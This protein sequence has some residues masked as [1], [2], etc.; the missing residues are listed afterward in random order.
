MS[1]KYRRLLILFTAIFLPFWTLASPIWLT[2]NGISPCWP[3][4]WLL[5]FS[6]KN[7]IGRASFAGTSLGFLMDAWTI[8]DVSYVP[9]F[10]LLSLVWGRYGILHKN[11][12]FTL[13]LGLM[14]ILGT[15]FVSFSIWIQK[16]FLYGFLRNNWFNSWALHSLISQ[17]IITGLVAPLLCSWILLSYKNN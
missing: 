17:L 7:G 1:R 6:L 15:A 12:E 13:N 3:L 5:P 8:G 9:S 11:I 2:I 10:L 16:I 4:L 14:A